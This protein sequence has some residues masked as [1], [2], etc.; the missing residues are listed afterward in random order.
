M[1]IANNKDFKKSLEKVCAISQNFLPQ[2]KIYNLLS[3]SY[4]CVMENTTVNTVNAA[5]TALW[6]SN[7]SNLLNFK[8]CNVQKRFQSYP[9]NMGL[10]GLFSLEGGQVGDNFCWRRLLL[11][12]GPFNMH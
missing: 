9:E 3:K 5:K 10:F 7:V 6:Q 12:P 2:G 8:C 4:Y 11:E 1:N